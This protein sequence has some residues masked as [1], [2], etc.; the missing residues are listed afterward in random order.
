MPVV[1][2]PPAGKFSSTYVGFAENQT[3]LELRL[4]PQPLFRYE[5]GNDPELIDGALF[6]FVQGTDPQ[7][8]LLLEARDDAK[9]AR[10]Y[11][12]FARMASGAVTAHY[13]DRE[14]FS[15]PKYDFQRN[16]TKPFLLL[17]MQIVE[18]SEV[19]K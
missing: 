9:T 3:P 18:E 7:S 1:R 19:S 17:P 5:T 4:L 2:H 8:L 10:W 16:P 15:V 12:A 14:V 13:Q 6:A 11:F